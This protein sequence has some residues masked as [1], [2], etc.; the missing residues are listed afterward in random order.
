MMKWIKSTM[1]IAFLFILTACG[2]SLSTEAV[3]EQVVTSADSIANYHITVK[4]SDYKEGTKTPSAQTIA[5]ASAW[6]DGTGYGSKIDKT[7]GKVTNQLEVIADANIG[8]IRYYQDKWEQ[9]IT[10]TSS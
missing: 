10:A 8:F 6:K 3:Q 5:S 9:T 4:Q 7:S 2:K 1:V